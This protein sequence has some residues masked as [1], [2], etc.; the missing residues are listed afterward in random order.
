MGAACGIGQYG[1]ANSSAKFKPALSF[2]RDEQ[3]MET[4]VKAFGDKVMGKLASVCV[5][6]NQRAATVAAR[7]QSALARSNRGRFGR[8]LDELIS[9]VEF[10]TENRVKLARIPDD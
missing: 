10:W 3:S 1:F 9:L 5:E 7:L 8:F 4:G 6:I 2:D